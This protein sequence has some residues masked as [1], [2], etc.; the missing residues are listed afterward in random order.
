MYAIILSGMSELRNKLR[1][2][3]ESCSKFS[4]IKTDL[5]TMRV[6]KHLFEMR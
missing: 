1:M 2:E 4:I 6:I 5:I 3:S